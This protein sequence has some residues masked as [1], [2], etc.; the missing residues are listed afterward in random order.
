[1]TQLKSGGLKVYLNRAESLAQAFGSV[2]Q[3]ANALSDSEFKA[4]IL[5]NFGFA[6]NNKISDN[7]LFAS[8]LKLFLTFEG[9]RVS[10]TEF[11]WQKKHML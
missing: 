1:M 9:E 2:D 11:E 7:N 6:Y 8:R 3:K 4:Y 10:L 5:E